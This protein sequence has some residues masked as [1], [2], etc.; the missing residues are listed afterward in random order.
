MTRGIRATPRQ[1][2]AGKKNLLKAQVLRVGRR[3]MKYQK[4]AG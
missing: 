4:R 3:G 2:I 1:K